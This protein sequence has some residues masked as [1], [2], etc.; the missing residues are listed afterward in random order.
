MYKGKTFL[1]VIPARSGSKRLPQKNILNLGGKPLI[2]WTIEAALKSKYLDKIVLSTDSQEMIN[3]AEKYSISFIK[4]PNNLAED[5]TAII[6]V[7][8]HV[9]DN[10]KE[11]FNYVVL[12]QPTSPLRQHYH[13]DRSIEFLI[14]KK[15]KAVISVTKTEFSPLWCNT[16]PKDLNMKNFLKKEL[17]N[18]R[19]QDL[20][21]FYRLNGAIYICNTFDLLEKNTFFLEDDI[22]AFVMDRIF[23]VDIDD[24]YDF[25]IAETFL[26]FL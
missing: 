3:I 17:V 1:A 6:D 7:V 25:L 24:I 5:T 11:K 16:L 21:V 10:I 23:S 9:I 2:C 4:R 8:R 18:K 20:P 26:K 15:A 13:I 14:K 22:Y 19:S 12:L